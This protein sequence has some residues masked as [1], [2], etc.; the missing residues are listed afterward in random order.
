[1]KEGK[2]KNRHDSLYKTVFLL[3][4]V[5]D[6]LLSL[7]AM[8][9]VWLFRRLIVDQRLLDVEFLIGVQSRGVLNVELDDHIAVLVR[10]VHQR[11]ALARYASLV[12]RPSRTQRKR[13]RAE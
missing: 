2:I 8:M 11:H 4:F 7:L 3:V 6:W 5:G 1:M 9:M 10:V 12:A 13:A